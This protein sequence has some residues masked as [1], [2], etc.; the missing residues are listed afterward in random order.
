MTAEGTAMGSV[1]ILTFGCQMNEYDSFRAEC[2]LASRGVASVDSPEKAD[3]VVLNTCCVRRKAETRVFGTLGQLSHLKKRRPGLKIVVAGC[4]AE[5]T[6]DE[7]ESGYPFIDAFVSSLEPESI[8]EVV[9]RLLPRRTPSGKGASPLEGGEKPCDPYP[10]KRFVPVSRGCD[11]FCTYCIVPY[12]R[13]RC[14]SLPRKRI[15]EEIASYERDGVLEITLIGQNVNSYEW[16]GIRFPGLLAEVASSFPAIRFRFLTSHP[17]D[18]DEQLMDTITSFE[19]IAKHVHLPMQSG[20][21]R[22]LELMNRGYTREHYLEMVARLREKIEDVAITTDIICGF[23]GETEEDFAQTLSAM[24]E[25]GFESSY[26][27]YYSPRPGTKAAQ[28]EG[29][30]PVEARKERLA[31]AIAH[32]ERISRRANARL[33]GRTARL[34]VEK[35]GTRRDKPLVAKNEWGLTVLLEGPDDL[36]GSYVEAEIVEAD[37]WSARA[38]LR[39]NG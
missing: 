16:E 4:M 32:Q 34:L 6:R 8:P 35:R 38:R 14:R 19:N 18:I 10:F 17:K 28:M 22:V 21:T 11:N 39:R 2:E 9:E 26:L 7:L 15:I 27:F 31:R 5:G 3:V 30:L 20:S 33:V 23:P 24:E 12:T 25:A 1:C 36:I 13:G 37:A 29:M